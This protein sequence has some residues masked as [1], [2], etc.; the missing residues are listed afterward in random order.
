MI[1]FYSKYVYF[2]HSLYGDKCRAIVQSGKNKGHRCNYK[3]K[4]KGNFCMRHYKM[5]YNKIHGN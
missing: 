2:T 4:C 1:P 5:L 3:V